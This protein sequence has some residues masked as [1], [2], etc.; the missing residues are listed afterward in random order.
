MQT[1]TDARRT[2]ILKNK[3]NPGF[4]KVLNRIVKTGKRCE[5]LSPPRTS[6]QPAVG[7]PESSTAD[8]A[9]QGP[10]YACM[11]VGRQRHYSVWAS[12]ILS[13]FRTNLNGY[14]TASSKL[15]SLKP[16]SWVFPANQSFITSSRSNLTPCLLLRAVPLTLPDHAASVSRSHC[17]LWICSLP[18]L[19]SWS[20]VHRASHHQPSHSS[21]AYSAGK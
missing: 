17:V 15:A 3:S 18:D 1:P 19:R 5:I 11:H 12:V 8:V 7:S 20:P 6:V 10:K 16:S 2:K 9:A 21:C 13:V 14:R 4:R